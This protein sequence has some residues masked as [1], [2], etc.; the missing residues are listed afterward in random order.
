MEKNSREIL[1]I[2]RAMERYAK[3]ENNKIET[4]KYLGEIELEGK[5]RD[6]YLIRELIEKQI[7]GET[8]MIEIDN[9]IT[10]NLEKIAGNNRTDRYN[11]PMA[12]EKYDNEK[13]SIEKQLKDLGEEGLLD[14]REMEKSRVR[15]IAKVLGLNKFQTFKKVTMCYMKKPLFSSIFVP[16]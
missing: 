13:D 2:M 12:I 15:E 14:L 16:I 8:K 4:I 9:Y 6:I 11:F 7:N 5:A 3:R 10:E 1:K